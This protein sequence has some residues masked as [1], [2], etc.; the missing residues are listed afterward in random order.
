L[1]LTFRNASAERIQAYYSGPTLCSLIISLTDEIV[2]TAADIYADL[3][4]RG[5]SIGDADTLI[6]A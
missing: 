1:S 4:Q 6:T 3:S 2:V 5:E